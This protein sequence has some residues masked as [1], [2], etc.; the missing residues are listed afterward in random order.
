M[1]HLLAIAACICVFILWFSRRIPM[2]IISVN[3]ITSFCLWW[4]PPVVWE[5]NCK[6]KYILSTLWRRVGSRCITPLILNLRTRL[7][8]VLR[9]HV[10]AVF[11]PGKRTVYPLSRRLAGSQNPSGRFGEVK[12]LFPPVG[13]RTP[14]RASRSIVT[15]PTSE[16]LCNICM[17]SIFLG[18]CI[19]PKYC[20]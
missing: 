18:L 2:L 3:T 6:S 9:L 5:V 16:C 12:N 7:W 15:I 1:Y 19:Y 4:R 10:P 14:D 17:N 20:L 13:I 11:S 8:W